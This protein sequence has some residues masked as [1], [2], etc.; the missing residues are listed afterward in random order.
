MIGKP[1]EMLIFNWIYHLY[2]GYEV[3]NN[4]RPWN[5]LCLRSMSARSPNCFNNF[6]L[7]HVA[8]NAFT[9]AN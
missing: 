9:I 4:L 2:A 5:I 3:S 1:L 8:Q 7:E 6:L